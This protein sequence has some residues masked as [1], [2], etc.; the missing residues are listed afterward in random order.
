MEFVSPS[1]TSLTRP[2]RSDVS[3]QFSS[4]MILQAY[5]RAAESC[6][7]QLTA[8]EGLQK[9]Y[10][11]QKP[12]DTD[13]Y[14]SV[15]LKLSQFHQDDASKFYDVS[16]KLA[17]LQ[18][19]RQDLEGAVETLQK[20]AETC[21]ED[22]EKYTD[23]L[24]TIT[25]ILTQQ[26]SLSDDLTS[27]LVG[28]LEASVTDNQTPT[29]MENLKHLIKLYYK[30]KDISSL[31][32]TAVKMTSLFPE[33]VYPLEWLC[34]VYLESVAGLW[35]VE[36]TLDNVQTHSAAL[37][38]FSPGNSL[39]VL[40][41]GAS[42]FQQGKYPDSV[43]SLR[44]GTE[45]L[46]PNIYGK[47]L[48]CRA[49]AELRDYSGLEVSATEALRLTSKIK[50]TLK[51]REVEDYLR[52][53]LVMALYSQLS[54][55]KIKKAKAVIETSGDV[56]GKDFTLVSAKIFATLGEADKAKELIE[57]SSGDFSDHEKCLV[58]ALLCRSAGDHEGFILQMRN[59]L[60]EDPDNFEVLVLLGEKLYEES[61]V[62]GSLSLFLRAAKL[63]SSHWLPFLYLGQLYEN[64]GEAGL[65]KARKCYQK[66]LQ[67]SGDWSE[68]A[69]LRLSDIYR[70][71]GRHED[72]LALLSR[73]TGEQ[74]VRGGVW[75]W[76]RLGVHYLDCQQAGRAVISLQAA[77]R[78]DPT[79]L[80][81][82]EAL[83]DAYMARGSFV[84]ARKGFEKVLSMDSDNVYSRLM[85]AD[86]KQRLG[87]HHDAVTDYEYLLEASPNYLPALRGLGETYLA[88]AVQYQ[89]QFVDD[90]VLD[91]VTSG[92]A[93]LTRAAVVRSE[94]AGTWRL[95]GETCGLVTSLRKT[96]RLRVPSLLVR[97]GASS[98]EE[99]ELGWR[100]VVELGVRCYTKALVLDQDSANTWHDLAIL[101]SALDQLDAAKS[102]LRRS[103]SL[104]VGQALTWLSLG[105]VSARSEDWALAQHCFV[106]SLQ[107]ENS[108]TCWTNLGVIYLHL[109][110]HSLANKAFKEA[111]NAEP[112]YIRCWTGQGLLAEI[113][114]VKSE[115]MDIFRHCTF[116][117]PE[118]ESARGYSDWVCSS[119]ESRERGERLEPHNKYILDK[120]HGVVVGVD[121]LT[122]YTRRFPHDVTALVQLGVLYERL[123]LTR[124]AQEVTAAALS[125]ATRQEERDK[126]LANLGRILIR[127]ERSEEAA[128]CLTSVSRPTLYSQLGL[129]M[130]QYKLS[131]YQA[132]Y[133]A[134]ESCLH[135]LADNDGLKSHILVAMGSLAYKVEGM[136]AAKTLLFQSCQLSPPSVRGLFALC[137]IGVQHS[138]MNLIEAAL[139]EMSP[140]EN[141]PRFAPD[142][143]FLRASIMVLKGEVQ[144]AKRSLLSFIHRRPWLAQLWSHLSLFLLQNSPK[145]AKFAARLAS[146]A[147]VMRQGSG[148]G[149]EGGVD[150]LVVGVVAMM[151]A[152]DGAGSLKRASQACH[153]FPHLAES[154]AVLVAAARL[155][156]G[157]AG[158]GWVG[159]ALSHVVRLGQDNEPLT[160]W[161]VR[162]SDTL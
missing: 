12:S 82:W 93:V 69:A 144:A 25:K 88:M 132:S 37:L 118:P 152:G 70:K 23:S 58:N 149:E 73:V 10:E 111:Q 112:D 136:E 127:L 148:E 65:E 159:G 14:L 67:L 66:S 1:W 81:C 140:H 145:D 2:S 30:I 160:Q 60:S 28:V 139:S 89:Q 141:D 45:G 131:N 98:Q 84:A 46:S 87:H 42:H 103:L 51:R 90:N 19:E 49:Q 74:G 97:P 109:G 137:V 27:V 146:K 128:A 13:H 134:Y 7:E 150:N 5:K 102:S 86:I 41:Q 95:L 83:A 40:A 147:G 110:E 125:L 71:M 4:K 8:W 33:N 78:S 54:R 122:A 35:Q 133:Q 68:D 129:A 6:P 99:E 158:K 151:M 17:Q 52:L 53:N 91:C 55:E 34:K 57:N 80:T 18:L 138:D 101:Q 94:L 11:K 59:I 96:A 77:L 124:S 38:R 63:N 31:V 107:L 56:E 92:L 116:L 9:F 142:I 32:K 79:N 108:A 114:G 130:A 162:V 117:G 153:Q 22:R 85:I 26:A 161:A 156:S 47:F 3:S 126:I 16:Q 113:T 36:E 39:A 75:A 29:N 48:L 50:N 21:K 76:L 155:S 105:L 119:L 135:Q 121:S 115:C 24:A 61:D 106:K 64:Q 123:G 143:A 15:L 157:P 62:N 154:W 104:E 44:T 120:M 72:N 100:D 43:A 20:Q